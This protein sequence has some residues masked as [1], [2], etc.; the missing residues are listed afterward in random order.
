MRLCVT[1]VTANRTLEHA[2]RQVA[3]KHSTL[4]ALYTGCVGSRV[5]A[6]G[7]AYIHVLMRQNL[8]PLFK[9]ELCRGARQ[10]F[11]CVCHAYPY[12]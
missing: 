6:A 3:C 8:I 2:R 9:V 7:A 12:K 11:V 5:T 4:V 1:A 10:C